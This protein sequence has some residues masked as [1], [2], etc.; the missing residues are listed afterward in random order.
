MHTTE[1]K[2]LNFM[3]EYLGEIE[4][5]FENTLASLSLAKMGSHH[6]K[7]WGQKSCDALPWRISINALLW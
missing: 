1:S 3:I 4:T 6:E 2:L 5:E 7:N